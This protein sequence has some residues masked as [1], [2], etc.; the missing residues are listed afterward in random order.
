VGYNP[1]LFDRKL[2]RDF[3]GSADRLAFSSYNI[4]PVFEKKNV[5]GVY[6]LENDF[7]EAK[8]NG[9]DEAIMKLAEKGRVFLQTMRLDYGLTRDEYT[10]LQIL[11]RKLNPENNFINPLD[12]KTYVDPFLIKGFSKKIKEKGN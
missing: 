2:A 12:C 6:E 8:N 5:N 3:F 10:L 7:R 4:L 1:K 11:M 9:D